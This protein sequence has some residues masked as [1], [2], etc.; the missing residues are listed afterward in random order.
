MFY[1]KFKN[2]ELEKISVT[3][4]RISRDA[5]SVNKLRKITRL[6][7]EKVMIS[8]ENIIISMKHSS[9]ADNSILILILLIYLGLLLSF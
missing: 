5:K 2:N 8:N 3:Y 6:I 7:V 9:I 4:A 1:F